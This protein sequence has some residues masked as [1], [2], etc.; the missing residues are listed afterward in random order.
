M[1]IVIDW[2]LFLG[3]GGLDVASRLG[4]VGSGDRGFTPQERLWGVFT[5]FIV[6]TTRSLGFGIYD[7][8]YDDWDQNERD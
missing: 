7:M 3:G 2:F 8:Y 1:Y 5:V 6:T 4:Y